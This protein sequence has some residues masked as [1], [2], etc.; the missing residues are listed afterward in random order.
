AV[1]ANNQEVNRNRHSLPGPVAPD[2]NRRLPEQKAYRTENR[3]KVNP[4]VPNS[5]EKNVPHKAIQSSIQA[6]E[7]GVVP[8]HITESV[9]VRKDYLKEIEKQLEIIEQGQLA[10]LHLNPADEDPML[11]LVIPRPHA[12][13]G[14]NDKD[15]PVFQRG[16]PVRSSAGAPVGTSAKLRSRPRTGSDNAGPLTV[17][18]GLP[19]RPAFDRMQIT[20]TKSPVSSP[21]S[22]R[23][24]RS[25]DI[26]K[27]I[28]NAAPQRMQITKHTVN[29]KIVLHLLHLWHSLQ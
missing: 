19:A 10:N 2:E 23:V 16:E 25:D 8:L 9:S 14:T 3:Y 26:Q 22:R 27:F 7:E 29:K 15:N 5:T 28:R 1:F 6:A 11:A 18:D 12:P 24:P 20:R 4:N 13:E 21:A 17:N